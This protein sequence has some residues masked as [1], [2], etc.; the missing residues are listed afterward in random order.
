M[1]GSGDSRSVLPAKVDA[2][3][4]GE[5]ALSGGL[6]GRICQWRCP[7]AARKIDKLP[8]GCAQIADAARRR[9]SRHRQQDTA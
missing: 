9:Q 5:C 4:Y 2:D 1:N 8:G 7:A 3:R 6:R